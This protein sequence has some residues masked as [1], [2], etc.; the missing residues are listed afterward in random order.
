MTVEELQPFQELEELRTVCRSLERKLAKAKAK[1]EDL[2]DAVE[3]GAK[4]AMLVLGKAPPI[5]KP[6][7]DKRSKREEVAFLMLSDW[8]I[9]KHTE[10]FDTQVA[11][12][13]L[14]TLADKVGKITEIERADH[15]VNT[16]RA[17]FAGDFAENTGI[18]PGQAFEVDSTTFEQLFAAALAG[19]ALVRRL[20]ATFPRVAVDEAAGN[21][22]RLGRKGDYAVT[23]N[24]DLLIYRIVRE[25]LREFEADG[26]LVWHPSSSWYSIVE[27]RNYRALLLH[28]HQIKS[29]GGNTPAFG[30]LRKA[31]AWASGVLG[32]QFTDIYMGHFHQALALPM[33]NGKGPRVCEP[34][35][36]I[37]L[38]FR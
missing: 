7:V 23:D 11:L 8:H 10:S 37:G 13:R 26:R 3:R 18:F 16:C 15:P 29:F 14:T 2:V 32:E 31:N 6:K 28:G 19:E 4:D 36:R 9:G 12:T 35:D 20:L 21:H 17:M 25:R 24:I 22:G 27:A 34:V 1:T 30:I 5:P 38:G 33:A